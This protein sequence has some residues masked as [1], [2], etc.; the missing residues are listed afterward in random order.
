MYSLVMSPFSHDYKN[1][2]ILM[3]VILRNQALAGRCVACLKIF[4]DFACVNG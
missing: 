2:S 3:K 4:G 1:G